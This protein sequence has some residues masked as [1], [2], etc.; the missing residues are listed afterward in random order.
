MDHLDGKPRAV[1]DADGWQLSADDVHVAGVVTGLIDG[2]LERRRPAT[3][4]HWLTPYL[5]V[6]PVRLGEQTHLRRGIDVVAAAVAIGWQIDDHAMAVT[7]PV[8]DG[9]P[10]G[11]APARSAVGALSRGAVG[12]SARRR[13]GR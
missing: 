4:C 6:D 11:A 7:G 1:G 9:A 10:T 3:P 13:A 5:D 2:G 12:G 8:G